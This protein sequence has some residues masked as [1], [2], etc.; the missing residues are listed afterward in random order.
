M[1]ALAKRITGAL[2]WSRPSNAGYEIRP[3]NFDTDW[4]GIDHLLAKEEWPIVRADLEASHGQPVSEFLVASKDD[5]VHGFLATH[6][7]EE[8][9]Y[10]DMMIIAKEARRCG[11]ARP[12]YFRAVRSLKQRGVRTLVVH[13]TN[14]SSRLIRLLR[15]RPGPSFTL[16]AR[17]PSTAVEAAAVAQL[18]PEDLPAL[19]ALDQTVFGQR[20]TEWITTLMRQPSN[21]FYGHYREGS[22]AA[23]VCL[24]ERRGG[25]ICIDGANAEDFD[26]LSKLVREVVTAHRG[27]R[28]QCIARTEGKLHRLLS[29]IGFQVPAFFVQI[30]P[31]VEWRKGKRTS[32]GTS[33]K[34]ETL[35]WF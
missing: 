13:T 34:I 23:S 6:A 29:E 22:L 11:L 9:G 25:A 16:L 14:D 27:T 3:V 21:T 32:I 15:F 17:D 24:R 31:L 33:E 8:I 7:F 19:I 28:I 10:L 26:D 20:R 4:E 18:G 1:K 12:M 5:S 30:G 35:N 2:G